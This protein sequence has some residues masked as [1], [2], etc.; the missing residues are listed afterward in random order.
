MK[1]LEMDKLDLTAYHIFCDLD[2][3]L[4]DFEHDV[5]R[6]TGL[7]P[8][9]FKKKTH[10]EY[11]EGDPLEKDMWR[12]LSRA[13]SFYANLPWMPGGKEL[14][15]KIK[16]YKPVIL[17]G[18]PLGNWASKQKREWCKKNLGGDVPVITCLAREKS[19]YA[20]KYIGSDDLSQAILIDD[21]PRNIDSWES[22]KGKGILHK[23]LSK[24]ISELSL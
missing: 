17:T 3:V 1:V 14:W 10:P 22:H 21:T 13:D 12:Q 5:Q 24:T 15:N 20:M 11:R 19:Q 7:H 9:Q 16:E 18:V 23:N 6:I 2:G 8:K 4:C